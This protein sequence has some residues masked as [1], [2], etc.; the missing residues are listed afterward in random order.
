MAFKHPRYGL[1]QALFSLQD[2]LSSHHELQGPIL[3]KRAHTTMLCSS[4][5]HSIHGNP[6]LPKWCGPKIT[7]KHKVHGGINA[8]LSRVGVLWC[9]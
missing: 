3:T 1:P 7:M 6:L 5:W 8:D 9:V 2:P 4:F